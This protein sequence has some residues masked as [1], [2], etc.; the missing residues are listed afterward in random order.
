MALSGGHFEQATVFR[1][2]RRDRFSRRSKK[3]ASR[4]MKSSRHKISACE[5]PKQTC[6]EPR[7]ALETWRGSSDL[8]DRDEIYRKRRSAYS[9][10]GVCRF[11]L[12]KCNLSESVV[13]CSRA[14]SPPT[15]C[16]LFSQAL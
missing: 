6:F 7:R 11:P 3:Y 13:R 5:G 9:L 10:H 8:G 12:A 16:N 15:H 14:E 2:I 4:G 1:K